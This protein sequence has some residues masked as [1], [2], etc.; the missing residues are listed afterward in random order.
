MLDIETRG[1]SGDRDATTEHTEWYVSETPRW[2]VLGKQAGLH[3]A[4]EA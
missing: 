4:L 2:H 3:L 1:D